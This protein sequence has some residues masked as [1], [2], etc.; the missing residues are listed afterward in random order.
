M[1]K[2]L[3]NVSK[4]MEK[5]KTLRKEKG[6]SNENMAHDLNISTSAYNKMERMEASISLERFI[7]IREILD[8]PYSEFFECAV[9]NV[10]KQDLKDSAIG[11]GHYEIQTLNQENR[12]T[13]KK[14][15]EMLEN[16]ILHL[17]DEVAFLRG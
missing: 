15:I 10:Y 6:Y 3:E 11:I 9:K 13:T 5:I 2:S 1:D 14:L 8:V 7:R 17:K 16:E 12:E 4:I